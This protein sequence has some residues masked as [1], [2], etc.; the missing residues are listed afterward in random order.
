MTEIVSI[1]KELCTGCG[2]CVAICPRGILFIDDKSGVCGVTDQ[3][4]CDRRAGCVW[5][6]PAGAIKVH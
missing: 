4:K 5:M 2:T 1:N 3:S 6:C